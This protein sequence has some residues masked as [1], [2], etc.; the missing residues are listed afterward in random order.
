MILGGLGDTSDEHLKWMRQAMKMV[1][2]IIV[3]TYVCSYAG[4]GSPSC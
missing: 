1:C 3:L 2:A 4:G